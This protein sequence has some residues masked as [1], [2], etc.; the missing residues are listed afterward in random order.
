MVYIYESSTLAIAYQIKVWC[1]W[2]HLGEHLDGNP[3]G[4]QWQHIGGGNK[5]EKKCDGIGNILENTLMGIP[6]ELIGAGNKKEKKCDGI[7]N[8]LENRLMGTPW[9]LNWQHIGARKKAKKKKM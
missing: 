6:W 8:I 7:G 2:E 3:L 5:K 9:E 4:T 1:Y